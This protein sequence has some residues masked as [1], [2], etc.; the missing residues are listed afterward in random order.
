MHF[1]GLAGMARRI[2]EYADG[3]VGYNKI[4]TWGSTITILS[5]IIFIII[6]RNSLISE[7]TAIS[8][9]ASESNV[10]KEV[11]NKDYFNKEDSEE[12]KTISNT[13]L[14]WNVGNPPSYHTYNEIARN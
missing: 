13:T 7:P 1:L 6:L 9:G 11:I 14:E 2:P 5:T 10:S 3:Y 4:A 8:G 12:N